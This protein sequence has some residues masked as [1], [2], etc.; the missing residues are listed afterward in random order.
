MTNNSLTAL[1]QASLAGV[2]FTFAIWSLALHMYIHAAFG[3]I[4][5]VFLW[6]ASVNTIKRGA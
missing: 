2:M 3:F 4:V 5:A 6:W 1:M